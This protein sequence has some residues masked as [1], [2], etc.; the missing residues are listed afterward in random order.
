M[1]TSR[2]VLIRN[3]RILSMVDGADEVRGNVLVQDGKIAALGTFEAPTDAEIVDAAGGIV[4]PGLIDTHRH[5]WQ[6]QLRTT[7][8][9][10]TLYDYLVH[11]RMTYSSFYKPDDVYLG[12]YVG[13]LEALNA[14]IT[15]IVDHCH[16]L[17]SPE[18]TDAAIQGLKDSQARAVFCYGLFVN[19]SSHSPFAFDG[20]M[21]WRY[22]DARRLRNTTFSSD[23]GK[24][25]LGL[26]PHE[27][28]SVPF[29]VSAGDLA[30]AREIAAH[31]VSC[32]VAMGA[33]DQGFQFVRRLHEAG[34]LDPQFL[35]VHGASLTDDEL[36]M[37]ADSG[38]G[39]SS[40][41]ETELQ[42]GM[43]Y[44]V[45]LRA[46]NAGAHAS[47]GVDIV[48]NYSG[49]L[50]AQMR[51]MIQSARA[52]GNAILEARG[53]APRHVELKTRDVLRL[54][55]VG[56]AETLRLA[57]KIGTLEVGKQADLIIIRTDT[58]NMLPATHAVAAVVYNAGP[59]D[60]SDVMVDGA[61]VKRS[62]SLVGVDWATLGG[63]L[64]ASAER[65]L[66]EASEANPAIPSSIVDTFFRN[67]TPPAPA[68]AE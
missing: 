2:A 68:A 23:S 41:P 64:Q 32:H 53:E 65:I 15:T 44:P 61:W 57:D 11:M 52:Q 24:I 37:I 38:A 39:I 36:K 30:F 12:N 40:T 26:A 48:S 49:D 63:R 6:T 67:L 1:S 25:L 34:L 18:H 62:G 42:M 33:Y 9:D 50:F 46:R 27:P 28:E 56:G 51:M 31:T 17:N 21:E 13:T 7:A 22:A 45:A 20:N 55:T 3:A 47:L 35:F 29:E 60:V 8:A 5:I 66:T 59:G 4:M 14:G 16:I 19:P 58:I 43:G 54:A 10:W